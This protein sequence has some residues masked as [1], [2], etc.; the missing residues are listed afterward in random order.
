MIYIFKN[1]RK[2]KYL[3]VISPVVFLRFFYTLLRKPLNSR[4]EPRRGKFMV[5]AWKALSHA[6]L[7]DSMVTQSYLD[8]LIET[9]P[10][11]TRNAVAGLRRARV[12][13]SSSPP[14]SVMEEHTSMTDF[15]YLAF[16]ES[17]YWLRHIALFFLTF[18][19][20][21]QVA[22][23]RS[24]ITL[25]GKIQMGINIGRCRKVAVPQPE[26]NALHIHALSH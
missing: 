9:C 18:R 16:F 23:Y 3:K 11:I 15:L 8:S 13:I 21:Q 10:Q 14:T 2:L 26:L 12:R 20:I 22:Y 5:Y 25:A 7:L 19:P 6:G 24:G 4:V 1:A 17:N